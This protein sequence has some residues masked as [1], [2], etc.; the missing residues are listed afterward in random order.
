MKRLF[1]MIS[2]SLIM[3]SV[4]AQSSSKSFLVFNSVKG[5][6]AK[7]M[8]ELNDVYHNMNDLKYHCFHLVNEQ[9]K[10]QFSS[11]KLV[12]LVKERATKIMTYYQ[13][14]QHVKSENMFLKYNSLYPILWLHKPT[15]ILTTSGKIV[16]DDN[17]KQCFIFNPSFDK[18]ITTANGNK[19]YFTTNAFETLDGITIK[20]KNISICIWEFT[21]KK[22]FVYA[23]LTTMA[24]K[25]MIETGGSFNIIAHYNGKELRLKKGK[26]Y[27]IEIPFLKSYPDMFTY[28]GNIQN[29]LVNWNVNKDE[30]VLVSTGNELNNEE[31]EQVVLFDEYGDAIESEY[32]EENESGQAVNFYELSAGKL[33]WINCDRFYDVKE[34][35]PL[36]VRVNKDHCKT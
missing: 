19:F 31:M 35:A 23:G 17:D 25:K 9:E 16:L 8:L 32:Y 22:S 13:E 21:N 6:T 34:T 33:G 30:P 4:T 2:I 12:K 26:L 29:G 7:N 5:L 11:Q 36:I 24:N 14:K 1:L 20:N 18:T 3:Y 10:A 15:S 28:Y 27:T